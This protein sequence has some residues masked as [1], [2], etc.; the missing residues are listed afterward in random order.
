M[1]V[2]SVKLTENKPA[3]ELVYRTYKE[4]KILTSSKQ[5]IQF[6]SGVET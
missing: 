3:Q 5:I 4:L 6:K 1:T 2:A